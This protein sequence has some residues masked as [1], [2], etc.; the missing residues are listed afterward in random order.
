MKLTMKLV[1]LMFCVGMFSSCQQTELA[2]TR[3]PASV[4]NAKHDSRP[5]VIKVK[6]N[7]QR[8]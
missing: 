3:E 4:S 5:N 6:E 2:K 1:I 7:D 8:H